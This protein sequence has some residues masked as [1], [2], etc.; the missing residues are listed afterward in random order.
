MYLENFRLSK[1]QL[2]F[3]LS[4]FRLRDLY[5]LLDNTELLPRPVYCSLRPSE[6]LDFRRGLP[7]GRSFTPRVRMFQFLYLIRLL[8]SLEPSLRRGL[9]GLLLSQTVC[10]TKDQSGTVWR[11]YVLTPDYFP[12]IKVGDVNVVKQYVV[13]LYLCLDRPGFEKKYP[14]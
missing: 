12:T 2:P 5:K 8:D 6:I 3:S 10:R 1:N 14:S 13:I 9:G 4:I 7:D 11:P